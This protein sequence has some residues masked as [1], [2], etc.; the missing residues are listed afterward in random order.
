MSTQELYFGDASPTHS[1]SHFEKSKKE[2]KPQHIK[3]EASEIRTLWRGA[4]QFYEKKHGK[5]VFGNA[6]ANL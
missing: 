5:P 2:L 6:L 3:L 1:C 4:I